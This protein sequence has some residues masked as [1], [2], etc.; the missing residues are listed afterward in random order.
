MITRI[1]TEKT[2]K[3]IETFIFNPNHLV[4]T[5][6][7]FNVPVVVHRL[8][9]LFRIDDKRKFDHI[10]MAIEMSIQSNYKSRMKDI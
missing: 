1:S 4:V 7:N 8:S 2:K 3:F 9:T 5:D 6:D 10:K